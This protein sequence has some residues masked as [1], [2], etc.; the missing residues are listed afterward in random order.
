MLPLAVVIGIRANAA[1]RDRARNLKLCMETLKA[2]DLP[3]RN[4]QTILIE[5]DHAPWIVP[6]ISALADRYQFAYNAG[7]YNRGWA[8]NIGARLVCGQAEYLLFLDADVLL[9]K[10][11]LRRMM[12]LLRSG[13]SAVRPYREAVF[14]DRES[15]ARLVD[16][17][18]ELP[19]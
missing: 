17:W 9:Q 2:Q 13:F 12:E 15:M 1:E 16:V 14:L 4:F 7:P 18:P 19:D 5:Q 6:E 3:S 11:S 10:D 8:F